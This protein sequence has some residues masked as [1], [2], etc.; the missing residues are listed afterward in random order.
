M[1]DSIDRLTLIGA[2]RK[3]VAWFRA[4]R[5]KPE[6]Y[7][8]PLGFQQLY[9]S[10]NSGQG[11]EEVGLFA[12]AGFMVGM[13]ED[14]PAPPS[15]WR[16]AAIAANQLHQW[17]EQNPTAPEKE[18]LAYARTVLDKYRLHRSQALIRRVCQIAETFDEML[19]GIADDNMKAKTIHAF[20]SKMIYDEGEVVGSAVHDLLMQKWLPEA[21]RTQA[22]RTVYSEF[23][24]AL[25]RASVSSPS[26]GEPK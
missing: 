9:Q 2:L 18:R 5:E 21:L 6:S 10:G 26:T 1:T 8:T 16:K 7:I 11:A 4:R 20:T 17:L 12:R 24:A 14:S 15:F 13:Y 22:P 23:A 25:G 19:A 3:G